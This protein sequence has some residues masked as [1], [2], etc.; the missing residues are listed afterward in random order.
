MILARCA[1]RPSI[2]RAMPPRT[3][4]SK[5]F[6][7]LIVSPARTDPFFAVK[8]AF[9][10][11]RSAL[12]A[13]I[14]VTVRDFHD[15]VDLMMGVCPLLPQV[16]RMGGFSENP[17]SS[18]KQKVNLSKAPFLGAPATPAFST[19]QSFFHFVP[20]PACPVSGKK[21]LSCGACGTGIAACRPR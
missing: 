1:G 3:H 15:P 6:K 19:G 13:M 10:F 17:D 5:C 21:N 4:R 12:V 16:F 20:W 9:G 18:R 2:N 8:N 14:P 7:V 11:F